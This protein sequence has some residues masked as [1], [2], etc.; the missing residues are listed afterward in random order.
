MISTTEF[1]EATKNQQIL[2][3]FGPQHLD[4][5]AALADEV[6]FYRDQ[7]IVREG[8]YPEFFYLILA[9]SVGL[10]IMAGRRPM[11]L[12]TL[13]TGDALAWTSLIDGGKGAHFE[14][15]A[16]TAGRAIAFDGAKL[17]EACEADPAFGY[18]LMKALL[19][20]V[21]ERLDIT[22]VQLVDAYATPA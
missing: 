2:K 6:D 14:A 18:H 7:V 20:L 11:L 19:S 13:Q 15:R 12:Q 3:A 10:E 4:R 16:L 8:E 22:R 21:T 9:G 5:L 1:I 17:R